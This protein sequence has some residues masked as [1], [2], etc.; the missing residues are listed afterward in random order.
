M[1]TVF[2]ELFTMQRM[3]CFLISTLDIKFRY[4]LAIWKIEGVGSNIH[5]NF[6]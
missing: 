2:L 6:V 3:L 1:D 5:E 4:H